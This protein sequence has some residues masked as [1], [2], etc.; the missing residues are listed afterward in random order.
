MSSAATNAEKKPTEGSKDEIN[1]DSS[2]MNKM[3][4]RMLEIDSKITTVVTIPCYSKHFRTQI[5][6]MPREYYRET[7]HHYMSLYEHLTK[8]YDIDPY[9]YR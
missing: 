8:L 7:K 3:K 4:A 9:I 6:K 5:A 2:Y 1:M